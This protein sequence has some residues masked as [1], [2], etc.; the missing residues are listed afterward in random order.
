MQ[1]VAGR[2][3]VPSARRAGRTKLRGPSCPFYI[4]GG[5][6]QQQPSQKQLNQQHPKQTIADQGRLLQTKADYSRPRQTMV[7]QSILKSAVLPASLMPLF[8][9]SPLRVFQCFLKLPALMD[10]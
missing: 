3:T 7:D 2:R 9:F 1:G 6:S 10:V 4:A 8:D 5:S